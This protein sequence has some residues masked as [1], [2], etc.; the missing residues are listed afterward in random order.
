MNMAK[1]DL[2]LGKQYL[3]RIDCSSL[4]GVLICLLT[5]TTNTLPLLLSSNFPAR[6]YTRSSRLYTEYT[7]IRHILMRRLSRQSAP[8]W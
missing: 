8:L 5:F 7:L 2:E 3:V 4:H 1:T 6:Q